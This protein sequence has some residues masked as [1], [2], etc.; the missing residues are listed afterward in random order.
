MAATVDSPRTDVEGLEGLAS[1]WQQL[2]QHHRAVAF[3]GPLVDDPELS[4]GRRHTWYLQIMAEGG[5]YLLARNS[6]GVPV[7]YAVV[8]ITLDDDDTF[9]VRNGICELVSLVVAYDHR[10]QGIGTLL[11]EAAEG[12]AREHAID[13]LKVSV[14]AGNEEA[15]SFYEAHDYVVAEHVL[16]R[17]LA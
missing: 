8:A 6:D 10:G 11:I 13:T 2:L 15:Q 7:G 3:Y 14:M 5:C 1:L 9:L 16:Y 17:R 12:V 4:W